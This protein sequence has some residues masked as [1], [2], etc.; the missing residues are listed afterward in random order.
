LAG[1]AA[2][3]QDPRVLVPPLLDESAMAVFVV[4]LRLPPPLPRWLA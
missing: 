1:V 4:I 2:P 3:P